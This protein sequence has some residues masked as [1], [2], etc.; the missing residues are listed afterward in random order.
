MVLPPISSRESYVT[1]Y[2]DAPVWLPAMRT[3]CARHNLDASA[4]RREALG[5]HVV[6]RT[7]GRILKLFSPLWAED[8]VAERAALEHVRGLPI[9]ELIGD[10]QLEGWPYMVMT[11]VPGTPA[12][13]VWGHL[14]SDQ[15]LDVLRQLGELMRVLHDHPPLAELATDWNGFLQER[16]ARCDE[17]HG[18]EEGWGAWI[19]ERVVG[20]SEPPFDP[21]LLSADATDEHI[22]LTERGG[23]WRI[24]GLIDF[25]DAMMGHPHYE[26][27]APLACHTF[28]H[29]ELSR[30]L[31]ESYG[32]EL[33][34]QLAERLTTYCLLHKFARLKDFLRGRPFQEGAG[35]YRAL[36]GDL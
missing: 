11:V 10:G 5:S 31:I 27:I 36:W 25:G 1:V 19:R 3:I 29:P 12:A 8:F 16:I 35:L 4:L 14:S 22:L 30:A 28:G 7:G 34:P 2:R 24:T 20:F 26:F 6:F 15:R 9:P 33:T 32:L 17:H 23:R 13:D 21:V 18:A